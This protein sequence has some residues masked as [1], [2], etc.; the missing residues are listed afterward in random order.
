MT[1]PV[2]ERVADILIGLGFYFFVD[3]SMHHVDSWSLHW[4]S[5]RHSYFDEQRSRRVGKLEWYPE[6][7]F[8]LGAL[9]NSGALV[10]STDLLDL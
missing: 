9:D 6:L 3:Y 8:V 1:A 5:I 7:L 2:V 10:E 4:E